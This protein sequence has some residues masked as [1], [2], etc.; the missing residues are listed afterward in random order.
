MASVHDKVVGKARSRVGI[1]T[2]N[3]LQATQA[4]NRQVVRPQTSGPLAQSYC[5]HI[6]GSG[7]QGR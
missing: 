6:P 4:Q 7:A 5:A 2:R 3:R 1:T